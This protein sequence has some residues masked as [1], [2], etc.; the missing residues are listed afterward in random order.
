M[1]KA[2][3]ER[4][5][6]YCRYLGVASVGSV[7]HHDR[8]TS[9]EPGDTPLCSS[10]TGLVADQLSVCRHSPAAL[11]SVRLGAQLGLLECQVQFQHERWNCSPA[12]S[13]INQTVFD[14]IVRRGQLL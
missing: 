2:V 1:D 11:L 3:R 13:H 4:D 14:N 9:V 12:A 5:E 7:D 10:L 8:S 6:M